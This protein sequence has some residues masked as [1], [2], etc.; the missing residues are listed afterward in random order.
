LEMRGG[1]M[2]HRSVI[3]ALVVGACLWVGCNNAFA[4][5]FKTL[6]WQTSRAAA[7]ALAKDQGKKILLVGG[8]YHGYPLDKPPEAPSCAATDWV[9]DSATESVNPNIRGVIQQSFIPWFADVD[10]DLDVNVYKPRV[11]YH[12]PVLCVIDPYNPDT[13]LYR[14]VGL[15]IEMQQL[16]AKLSQYAVQACTADISPSDKA[17]NASISTGNIIHVTPSASSCSWTAVRSDSWITITSGGSGVGAGTVIYS[18]AA[19]T[20]A[21]RTGTI[22]IKG[23]TFNIVQSGTTTCASNISPSISPLLSPLP[24]HT[25]FGEVP[26]TGTVEVIS[27]CSWSA[28]SDASWIKVTAPAG[29]LGNGNGTVSYSVDPNT[30]APRTGTIT[31]GGKTFTVRQDGTVVCTFAISPSPYPAFNGSSNSGTI[32]VTP[33]ASSC[34]W[35]AT[36]SDPSWMQISS[37][38]GTGVGN[39]AFTIAANPAAQRTGTITIGDQTVTISQATMTPLYFPY[40]DTSLPWQTEIGIINTSDQT[41][42]GTLR[43]FTYL[44]GEHIEDKAVTIPALGRKQYILS[45]EFTDH[46]NIG[47]LIFEASS[48]AVQG[49]TKFYQERTYRAAFPAVKEVNTSNNIYIT[50][51]GSHTQ[52]WWTGLSLLNTTPAEKLLT[53]T[54]NNGHIKN[55]TIPANEQWVNT[56]ASMFDNQPPPDIQS[57]EI[58]NASGIIGLELFGNT[59]EGNQM[60]GLLLTGNTAKTIYYPHVAGNGWGTGIVAYNPSGSAAEIRITPYS[61]Q[62]T[63]L[64]TSTLPLPGKGK[65][66]GTPADLGLLAETAWF[67]IDSTLPLSG[68]ELFC[69]IGNQQL[70]AYAGGAGTGARAGVFAKIEKLGWT[71]I[72]FVNTE[73]SGGKV[74]LTPYDD[75][76]NPAGSPQEIAVAGYE[77][78]AKTVEDL[79]P[80]QVISGATYIR[81]SSERNIVG[82]QLN[83]TED[84]MM[85]DGLPAL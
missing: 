8:R 32:T 9:I 47:Y 2:K 42:T 33:S 70:A 27:T 45:S 19:N 53:I 14:V 78:V 63:P 28:T 38:S 66:V 26:I 65:Y 25:A 77:K 58:T 49:Y 21:V 61:A 67:R 51:I 82:L 74:T 73:G 11:E 71:R 13:Y 76:G 3:A 4:V 35:S 46:T 56:I 34:S 16:Y 40:V 37:G 29:V 48:N 39:V 44:T 31:I 84:G 60:D 64:L 83:G 69:T 54:F 24:K 55:I 81:Y 17:F 57:A 59:F 75:N 30:G 79:F 20:G 36:S 7:V 5:V 18:V 72:I 23:N 62:G 22:T 10:L 43:A 68:F 12:L 52:G 85:L 6:D 80:P 1:N 41:V 15:D 50:H